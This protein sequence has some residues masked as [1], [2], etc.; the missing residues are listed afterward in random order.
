M[1]FD[2]Y[3]YLNKIKGARIQ[4]SLIYLVTELRLRYRGD[5]LAIGDDRFVE[6]TSPSICCSSSGVNTAAT[7]VSGEEPVLSN[8][9]VRAQAFKSES[10]AF[11]SL[12]AR[13]AELLLLLVFT[14]LELIASCEPLEFVNAVAGIVGCCVFTGIASKTPYLEFVGLHMVPGKLYEFIKSFAL[15]ARN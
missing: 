9:L 2:E 10:S 7:L 8:V 4:Q 3:H 5:P 13:S 14:R 12:A 6:L 1:L 11:V 15:C